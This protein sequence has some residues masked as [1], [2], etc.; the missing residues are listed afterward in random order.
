MTLR[1]GLFITQGLCLSSRCYRKLLSGKGR[2]RHRHK[3]EWLKSYNFLTSEDTQAD[4]EAPGDYLSLGL[5]SMPLIPP[6]DS[7][8]VQAVPEGGNRSQPNPF[9]LPFTH[10]PLGLSQAE[11]AV[12]DKIME[13]ITAQELVDDEDD[14]NRLITPRNPHLNAS[15]SSSDDDEDASFIVSVGRRITLP[16]GRKRRYQE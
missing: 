10:Q 13:E 1:S 8:G 4:P 15:W 2:Q 11:E 14:D 7:S 6:S 5:S 3:S 12:I 16:P 9:A